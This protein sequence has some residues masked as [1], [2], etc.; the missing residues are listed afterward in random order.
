MQRGGVR[1]WPCLAAQSRHGRLGRRRPGGGSGNRVVRPRGGGRTWS[2]ASGRATSGPGGTTH[3]LRGAHHVREAEGVALRVSRGSRPGGA[4]RGRLRGNAGSR[5]PAGGG[6]GHCTEAPP[7]VTTLAAFV[8][9]RDR[10]WVGLSCHSEVAFMDKKTVVLRELVHTWPFPL[11]SF[12]QLLQECAHCSRALLQE[13]PSTESMQAVILGLTARLHTPETE[14]G[15]QPLCRKHALRVLD[16]TGLLDDGVE[17]DPGT[18]SMWD[19]TAAVAR[20]CI[21]Q[22]QG[23]TAEPGLAPIPVE[24]RVDLRVNRASYAFLR[25]ALRSS[26]GSPLR[27]CCRDLRAE[28][29][30][31]R[32]T[33]A[34]L[35]LLDAGCLRRVDLRF[36]N[37]GLRGLSVI[38]PH[39]ARFQHLASLRLHYVHGDSRQPSVDGEDN[40]RYFL[41][42]MG[43]FTC[44]RELSM[45]SSLLSGR[46]DQL[47]STL[48]SP[49]ES[50]ELAFCALL[51]EDLRFLARSPHADHLKKL[52]L[53]GNDLSGSQLEPFQ[54][55]LRAAAATLLHLEL[56]ECQLADTQLLATLP[57]LTRCT[58]LRYLGLYGNPLSMAGLKEL[59][60]DSVVQAELRTVVHPFPVDC[61]EGLP[62]PPPASVLLEASINEEK[63]ARVEAEL[64]QLLLAS[65]RAHVLWTTDIYGRLAADYFSL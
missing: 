18:M 47:L 64:H 46:L 1:P 59:L 25:E 12:Q 49:L 35:Q 38:I 52:D 23:G 56:T 7:T 22:Q 63:F 34:L 41:A 21:A 28:D 50:L 19:C 43:R 60:R 17:Q 58:S 39:V 37:L 13:R 48:Q 3:R 29:L 53:S 42:Q 40:F 2:P 24:V 57:V 65:G 32:N 31:M 14:A 55:L 62:W 10:C 16:M 5:G 11:L 20:T 33:V 6:G 44:L 30:P 51:P 9:S 4:G 15:T 27:L 61:Y 8:S 45:G 36:N 54:G 26:V